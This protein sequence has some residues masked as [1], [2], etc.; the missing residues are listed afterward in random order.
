MCSVT[1]AALGGDGS[2]GGE[3]GSGGALGGGAGG[4]EGGGEGGGG[5]GGDSSGQKGAPYEASRKRAA[6]AALVDVRFDSAWLSVTVAPPSL[7][8]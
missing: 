7:T 3:G 6:R 2:D 1:H 5:G 4:G 8:A